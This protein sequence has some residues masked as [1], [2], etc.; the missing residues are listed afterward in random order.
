MEERVRE[1]DTDVIGFAEGI[2]GKRER[3]ADAPRNNMCPVWGRIIIM[4]AAAL[5]FH[6]DVVRN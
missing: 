3:G 6:F 4:T 2:K 1:L 5:C